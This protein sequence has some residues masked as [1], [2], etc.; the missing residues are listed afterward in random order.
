M[1]SK[2]VAAGKSSF[3]LIDKDK[4]FSVLDVKP[5]SSLL[6]PGC[7]IGK[8]TIELAKSIGAKGMIYAV[9]LWK[10][11]IEA[12]NNEIDACLM[13]TIIHDLSKSAQ[14][15]AIKEVARI[16]KP[17]SMLT[18]IEFKKIDKG[19]GPPV[20]IRMQEE[21]IESLILIYGFTKVYDGEAGT[22]NYILKFKKIT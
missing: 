1:S 6:D 8:Y 9:D 7:G 3:D 17:G 4:T 13:A 15:A 16:L 2:P 12:L 19:P 11:G 21:E 22:F 5:G 18:I 20:E 14:K 10:E